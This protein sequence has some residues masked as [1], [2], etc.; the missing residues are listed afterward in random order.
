MS[1]SVGV[2]GCCGGGA[3]PPVEGTQT[4][5]SFSFHVPNQTEYPS[6]TDNPAVPLVSIPD[7]QAAAAYGGQMFYPVAF[8]TSGILYP[9]FGPGGSTEMPIEEIA[10][11]YIIPAA[12]KDGVYS[13]LAEA[14]FI[15][16]G[17]NPIAENTGGQPPQY[18]AFFST[19][20]QAAGESQG[21]ILLVLDD[22]VTQLWGLCWSQESHT[23]THIPDPE[24]GPG[25][26]VINGND[27][28]IF[29]QSYKCLIKQLYPAPGGICG[30]PGSVFLLRNYITMVRTFCQPVPESLFNYMTSWWSWQVN[31]SAHWISDLPP[32][33]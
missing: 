20:T 22:L 7:L 13:F 18:N 2:F 26:D 1:A 12:V 31:V 28:R 4:T 8:G 15:A 21:E 23:T 30:G 32:G 25:F 6:Q 17:P 14:K 27:P 9:P 5:F 10:A 16:K 11:I 24:G 33:F 29:S 19:H 3:A